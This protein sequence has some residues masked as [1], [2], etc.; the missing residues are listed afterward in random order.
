MVVVPVVQ[1]QVAL[2][3][4]A[5]QIP[6]VAVAVELAAPEMVRQAVQE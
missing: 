2:E 4:L 3:R 5:L 6:V 1:S